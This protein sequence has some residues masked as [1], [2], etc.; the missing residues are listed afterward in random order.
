V[1]LWIG[2]TVYD[3]T[4][5]IGKMFFNIGRLRAALADAWEEPPSRLTGLWR[6]CDRWASVRAEVG[7]QRANVC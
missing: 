6:R 1:R 4:D 5:P 3:P 7:R 2:E